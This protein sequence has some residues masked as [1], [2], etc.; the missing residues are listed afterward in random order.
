MPTKGK[1]L[2]KEHK[3]KISQWTKSRWEDGTF[4]SEEHLKKLSNS[5][6]GKN[7]PNYIDGRSIKPYSRDFYNMRLD[8]RERD[9]N[10]CKACDRKIKGLQGH[11]HHVDGDKLNNDP[12]N[13]VLLCAT[14]HR[15][16]HNDSEK[17]NPMIL[18]FRSM[19]KY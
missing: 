17:M 19:L 16:V 14:C 18:I 3:K 13:L 8:I 1:K 11:I 15:R 4:G 6:K 7:N 10:M 5:L 12:Y 2:S 9:G